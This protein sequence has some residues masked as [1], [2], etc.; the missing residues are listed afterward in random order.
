MVS[1]DLLEHMPDRRASHAVHF[2]ISATHCYILESQPI[3][4]SSSRII[5]SCGSGRYIV[6]MLMRMQHLTGITRVLGSA[7]DLSF[8]HEIN[9]ITILHN[10][11]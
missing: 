8:D 2:P 5:V 3:T 6:D 4:C 9:Y 10:P 11:T 7:V 1:L